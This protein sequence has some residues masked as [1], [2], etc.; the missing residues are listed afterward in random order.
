[1]PL[2]RDFPNPGIEFR[3]PALQADSSP[4]EPAEK[5]FKNQVWLK[6]FWNIV[7]LPS[8][9]NFLSF[10]KITESHSVMS[11]SLQ[12]HGLYCPWNPPG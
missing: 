9:S 2:S 6:Y 12:P 10:F 4:S 7:I 8:V 1:M 5:P 11:N 3:S